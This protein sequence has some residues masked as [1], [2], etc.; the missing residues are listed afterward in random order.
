MAKTNLK[1]LFDNVLIKPFNSRKAETDL[2]KLSWVV[3]VEARNPTD[4]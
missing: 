2:E 1:P 3:W 4:Y